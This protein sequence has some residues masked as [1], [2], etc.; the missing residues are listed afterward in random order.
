MYVGAVDEMMWVVCVSVTEGALVV[1]EV[2]WSQLCVSMIL[3]L[4]IYCPE[5]GKSEEGRY[6]FRVAYVWWRCA[7][8]FVIA[9]CGY[10][11]IDNI[12][13]YMAHVGFY[14]CCN[15]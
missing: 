5:L 2:I 3:G 4:F 7:Q 9:S 1:K 15:D 14:E 11:H 13:M 8:Y 10:I 12:C 6:L